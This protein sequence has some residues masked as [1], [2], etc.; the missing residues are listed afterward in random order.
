M[1]RFAALFLLLAVSVPAGAI[2]DGQVSYVGGTVQ[3]LPP[4]AIG[5]LDMSSETEIAFDFPSKKLSMPYANIISFEY[6]QEVAHHLGVLPA[7]AVGL[8]KARQR[9]HIFELRFKDSESPNEVA[10]V[11]VSKQRSQALLAVLRARTVMAC[12]SPYPV[13]CSRRD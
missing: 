4:G 10:V 13:S 1:K 2:D 11:E 3:D 8:V 5:R 7:I 9:R 6:R 12:K